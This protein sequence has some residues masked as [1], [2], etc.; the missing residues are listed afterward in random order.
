MQ[1]VGRR[2]GG[3]YNRRRGRRGAL[4]EGRF[5]CGVIE[6]ER[7]LIAATVLI[8]CLPVQVGWVAHAADWQWSSA[9]HHL[10]RVRDPLISEHSVYW[11]IGNTPFEREQAHADLIAKGV[12]P[13]LAGQLD[14]VVMRSHALGSEAFLARIGQAVNRAIGPGRRGRPPKTTESL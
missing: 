10:G 5:R 13:D 14:A 4:W 6:A 8:E 12:A 7:Y 2:F 11:S 3:G 9:P 1:V